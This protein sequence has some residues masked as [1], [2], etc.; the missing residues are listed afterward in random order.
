MRKTFIVQDFQHKFSLQLA[1]YSTGNVLQG[2]ITLADMGR[3]SGDIHSIMLFNREAL[4]PTVNLH[5]FSRSPDASTVTDK[6]AFVLHEDDDPAL[7]ATIQVSTW[8]DIASRKIAMERNLGVSLPQHGR[9]AVYVVAEFS[10]VYTPTDADAL[11]L[12]ISVRT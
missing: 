5:F 7:F 1:A 6:A 3:A 4:M 2:I 11:R 9:G 8:L 12:A 10:S